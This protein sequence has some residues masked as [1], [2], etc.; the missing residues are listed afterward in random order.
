M[1]TIAP[2][3]SGYERSLRPSLALAHRAPAAKRHPERGSEGRHPNLEEV[4]VEALGADDVRRVPRLAQPL[5]R[6]HAPETGQAVDEQLT[7]P[8]ARR[9]DELVPA[10]RIRELDDLDP[11]GRD[12]P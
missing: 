1:Q 3:A 8:L 2:V 12:R 7:A 5:E 4:A 6:R 10:G 9:D 11:A